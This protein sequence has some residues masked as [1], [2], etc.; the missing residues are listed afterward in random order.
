[1]PQPSKSK[2]L[3]IQP[4]DIQPLESG[5]LDI[6]PLD[7]QPVE[8]GPTADDI[9]NYATRPMSPSIAGEPV[10]SD[11]K[12]RLR[13]MWDLAVNPLTDLP[14]R[15]GRSLSE[16]ITTPRLPGAVPEWMGNLGIT[17]KSIAQMKGFYGGALEGIGD[18]ISG[19]T[20]PLN[21]ATLG[22]GALETVGARAGLGALARIGNY[23][24]RGLSAPVVA[25]GAYHIGTAKS[26]TD[27]GMGIAEM[28]GGIA[29]LKQKLPNIASRTAD[30]PEPTPVNTASSMGR[31]EPILD[32]SGRVIAPPQADITRPPGP[33]DANT[34]ASIQPPE[35]LPSMDEVT[36]A[37]EKNQIT[38]EHLET[39]RSEVYHKLTDNELI[40]V[41][42]ELNRDA[43]IRKTS[44]AAIT[45]DRLRNR[46]LIEME[47][48]TR[49]LLNKLVPE[50]F[51]DPNV[52]PAPMEL[53]PQEQT[54]LTQLNTPQV[55]AGIPQFNRRGVTGE[56]GNLQRIG[57]DIVNPQTGEIIDLNQPSSIS[58]ELVIRDKIHI[59]DEILPADKN[60]NFG[61]L[62]NPLFGNIKQVESTRHVNPQWQADMRAN[63]GNM[64]QEEINRYIELQ[65]IMNGPLNKIT[66][67]MHNEFVTLQ[68]KRP[69]PKQ[70]DQYLLKLKAEQ[71]RLQNIA[72]KKA[73]TEG[74]APAE[75]PTLYPG[76]PLSKSS[77][78]LDI[79]PMP[80]TTPT[81]SQSTAK[82]PR[83]LA[84]GKPRYRIGSAEYIPEFESDLD[85]ALWII[86]QKTPSKRNTDYMKWIMENTGMTER[87]TMEAGIRIRGQI[88]D[89]VKGSEPGSVS[90]PSL[91]KSQ[92][93]TIKSAEVSGTTGEL[94]TDK[95]TNLE[96]IVVKPTEFTPK[97]VKEL[98]EQGY[99]FKGETPDGNTLFEKTSE[100][101]QQPILETE[102][103]AAK[104]PKP[105]KQD[106]SLLQKLY[107][108]PRGLMSVDL[109]FV[110]SASFRQA[111]PFV[112]T[113]AWFKAWVP[114]A[115]AYGSKVVA[116]AQLK[117]IQERPLFRST[118]L[119]DGTIQPS[120]AEKVGLRLGDINSPKGRRIDDSLKG[121][122]AERIPVYG[123]HIAGSNRAFSA[124]L[125]DLSANVFEMLITDAQKLGKDPL[126][127]LALGQE[128]AEFVNTALK[129]GTLGFETPFIAKKNVKGD[130]SPSNLKI[131]NQQV[132]LE[133]YS[134]LLA[135]TFFSPRT[136]SSQMR[137][138][139]PSTYVFAD[140]FVRKQYLK[141][142]VRNVGVW[143]TI[144]GLAKF[145][146]A[147]VST[148]PN[149]ADFGK[150]RIGDTRIDVPGGLQQWLV[151]GNRTLPKDLGGGGI[152]ST[153][154]E[155]FNEFGRGYKPETRFSNML[156]FG[157]N[158]LHPAAKT[159]VDILMATE[160]EPFHV[161]DRT[162]QLMA[163][164]LTND[165]MDVVKENPEL[166]PLIIGASSVGIG[167]QTYE[168]SEFGK[169]TFI[170]SE[171]DW[172]IGSRSRR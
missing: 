172:N 87:E 82:L 47:L 63:W 54:Y 19:F 119:K 57:E 111:A 126:N 141:A 140:P 81:I 60:F 36:Q 153:A 1:M 32:E 163:P 142:M 52:R 110:T 51:S 42:N 109:P 122:L 138:L 27:V 12:S 55:E 66:P 103:A 137:M 148:D 101:T 89:I 21:L 76:V 35:I 171:Y 26:P 73:L 80:E 62:E 23:G 161:A 38:P 97:R 165:L 130:Y 100:G 134:R 58:N 72:A 131:K 85:K 94:P 95:K 77:Q 46:K 155:K 40:E 25:Q 64:S 22:A 115:K 30:I 92:E 83:D 79:Q 128:I 71:T 160:R 168:R 124:Y 123:K 45:P 162:V 167:T 69:G 43:L 157:I 75:L 86:S 164:L 133:K 44:G 33:W 169:P 113:K 108:L 125:N 56:T 24:V 93:P 135:N 132:K 156:K 105:P 147:K 49:G 106:E 114:A 150:I 59:P 14:S 120:Y 15:I 151:L 50:P 34:P 102:V 6:Q 48:N 41:A 144:A 18:V 13:Q 116:D 61:N 129:R 31:I 91:F 16:D 152:T 159:A 65:S 3:D 149:S 29:G 10:I 88:K 104:P 127:N 2:K 53:N 70:P 11:N 136:I 139:N 7:I 74:Q 28:A 117:A 154:S 5:G 98:R 17:D 20:S 9:I 118:K 143:W 4:L 8:S 170:P 37:W 146:G 99:E 121:E 90:I 166:S 78:A 39:L 112:G 145:G 158:R 67:E 84:G 68:E 96:Q 107:D